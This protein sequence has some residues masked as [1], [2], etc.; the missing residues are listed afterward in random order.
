VTQV[1]RAS[2]GRRLSVDSA[3]DPDGKPVFLLH[4]TPGSRQGPRPRGIVLYRLGI[5]LITYDRP[6]YPGS[7]RLPG[8]TVAAAAQDVEAIADALEIDQ[9]SVIGRSGGAPHALA[10]AALLPERVISTAALCSLAPYDAEDL[11]WSN[12]MT[13]SNVRAYR[14]AGADLKALRTI[15]NEQAGQVRSN[16]EGLLKLLWPELDGHDKEVIGNIALR[17]IIAEV[18]TQALSGTIDGWI[19]DVV[20]L[21]KSW[22]F[23]LSDIITPV[24][25]WSGSEDAFSPAA[26]AGWLADHIKGSELD[27]APG[28]AHFGAVEILPRTLTWVAEQANY[29]MR[30]SAA[31]V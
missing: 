10:C 1:V 4:G 23:E 8:R 3:G 16:S 7:D 17:R 11:D 29:S 27:I 30:S 20:A 13:A 18:H 6:G 24:R 9:F 15:L 25:L 14:T 5:R 28:A 31:S 21:S 2:D 26:H 22:A 19:D 12:G